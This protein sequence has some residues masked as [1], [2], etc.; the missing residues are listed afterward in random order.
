MDD[1][2][3]CNGFFFFPAA[4]TSEN[5]STSSPCDGINEDKHDI[6]PFSTT[7]DSIPVDEEKWKS[8]YKSR[9][10]E[11]GSS[12]KSSLEAQPYDEISD[13]YLM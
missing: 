6:V 1:M 4:A 13:L 9:Y 5:Y 11:G 12:A 7:G 2:D 8:Y 3:L 10:K